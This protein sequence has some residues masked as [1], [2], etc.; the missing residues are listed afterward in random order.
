VQAS[1]AVCAFEAIKDEAIKDEAIKDEP[2]LAD[3]P[4]GRTIKPSS[5][6]PCWQ[7]CRRFNASRT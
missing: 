5:P 4:C 3:A 2:V 6:P 1:A 7:N